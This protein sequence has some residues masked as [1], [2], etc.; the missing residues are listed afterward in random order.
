[1]PGYQRSMQSWRRWRQT[2]PQQGE[3]GAEGTAVGMARAGEWYRAWKGD[4]VALGSGT[5]G[6]G[7]LLTALY[8]TS[9]LSASITALLG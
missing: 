1:M 8:L 3:T 6:Q 5:W 7:A 9:F 2:R 4:A